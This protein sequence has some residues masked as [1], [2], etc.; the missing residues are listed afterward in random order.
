MFQNRCHIQLQHKVN[1]NLNHFKIFFAR[2]AFR[3]RPIH[4]HIRPNC[5]RRDAVIG[6]AGR[7]IIN[8]A[9]NQAHPS[10]C[11]IAVSHAPAGLSEKS[12]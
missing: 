1:L 5:A 10:F 6:S 12:Q 7:F 2:A 9:T 11:R 4:G 3:T 8:P